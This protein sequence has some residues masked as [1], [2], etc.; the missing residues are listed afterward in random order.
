MICFVWFRS[1]ECFF[2]CSVRGA[3]VVVIVFCV[4]ADCFQS[5]DSNIKDAG[6]ASLFGALERN[7]TLHTL[8]LSS[9]CSGNLG[10]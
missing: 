10:V 8:D 6:A 3:R 2:V 4:S 9:E 1:F 5:S 7:T